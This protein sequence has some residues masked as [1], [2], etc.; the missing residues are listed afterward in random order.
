MFQYFPHVP[1]I[2]LS[3]RPSDIGYDNGNIDDGDATEL[4]K[5]YRSDSSGKGWDRRNTMRSF[6]RE[7][8]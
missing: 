5:R 4:K 2:G 8:E 7:E 3:F 6:H 1:L